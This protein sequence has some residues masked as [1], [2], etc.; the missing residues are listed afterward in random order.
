[1]NSIQYSQ[2]GSP[3]HEF[4]QY[5][6]ELGA[7]VDPEHRR[8]GA[9]QEGPEHDDIPHVQQDTQDPDGQGGQVVD[10]HRHQEHKRARVILKQV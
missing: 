4:R 1:M 10:H 8:D 3:A 9:S 2:L 5:C 7:H 6:P